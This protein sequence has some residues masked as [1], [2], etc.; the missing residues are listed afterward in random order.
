LY[1]LRSRTVTHSTCDSKIEVS[2]KRPKFTLWRGV[3]VSGVSADHLKVLELTG[4]G[5]NL[6]NFHF[7]LGVSARA[8]IQFRAPQ[9]FQFSKVAA[10][11]PKPFK[12][13][14]AIHTQVAAA[15]SRS[16]YHAKLAATY[17]AAAAE[18]AQRAAEFAKMAEEQ[19]RLAVEA[20]QPPED[21]PA[22]A[23]EPA[24]KRQR[25]EP[26]EL[27]AEEVELLRLADEQAAEQ[28]DEQDKPRDADAWDRYLEAGIDSHFQ[29]EASPSPLPLDSPFDW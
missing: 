26:R 8:C 3:D 18:S 6:E 4:K 17:S 16:A 25:R 12:A 1:R 21:K 19:G 20:A 14:E 15:I 10:H 23:V 5:Q 22:E 13:M 7:G 29:M 2:A 9:P 11:Q 24:A 28:E 27:S